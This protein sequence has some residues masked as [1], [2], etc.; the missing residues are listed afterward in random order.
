MGR[1]LVQSSAARAGRFAIR[2]SHRFK[3]LEP[4]DGSRPGLVI[5]GAA[6]TIGRVLRA[7]L[8]VSHSLRTIDQLPAEGIDLAADV[9][10]SERMQKAFAGASAVVELAANPSLRTSWEQVLANNL[11]AALGTLE[12]ARRAGVPRVVVA[13]SNHVTG[14]HERDEPYAS[15]L[16]GRYEGLD[17][18][19]LPRIRVDSPPRPDSFYAIGKCG[20]EAAARYY[21]EEYG[22]SAI[23]LRIGTVNPENRPRNPREFATLLTHRDLAQLV[24]RCLEAPLDLGFAVFYGVSRNTWRIWDIEDAAA[25]IGYEPLDDAE[26][27]R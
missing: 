14:M 25:T 22:M 8:A 10:R 3:P 27:F 16:A 2:L 4:F 1:G 24:R 17:P 23:C 7:E 26:S 18:E 12:A 19:S 6:G 9:R 11:A 15:V 13:S 20:A 21:A 5:T